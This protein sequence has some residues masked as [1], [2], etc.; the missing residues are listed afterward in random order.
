MEVSNRVLGVLAG[1]IACLALWS[2]LG[3]TPAVQWFRTL[4]REERAAQAAL[5]DSAQRLGR[6]VG[7]AA[8]RSRVDSALGRYPI[9][10]APAVVKLGVM[11]GADRVAESLFT[12][13]PRRA[14]ARVPTRLALVAWSARDSLPRWTPTSFALL[15]DTTRGGNCT[16]FHLAFPGDTVLDEYD[17]SAWRSAPWDGAVGACWYLAEFGEPGPEVRAWLDSRYWD[18]AR[19]VPPLKGPLISGE[20]ASEPSGLLNRVFGDLGGMFYGESVALEGCAGRRPEFCEA[21]FLQS[22]YPPNLLPEGVVGAGHLVYST[23]AVSGAWILEMP[24]YV[25]AS[26]LAL[27]VEDLGPARF[28]EFWTSTAPVAEAFQSVAGMSLGEWY[29][30]QLL[31][32]RRDAGYPEPRRAPVWPSAIGVLALALGGTMRLAR[33]RQV[34]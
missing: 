9:G 13:I 28:T 7:I 30:L 12:S 19:S 29:R 2:L 24:N 18:V 5:R 8:L 16:T 11:G 10:G 32:Q 34:R 33:R 14:D 21:A 31:E 26:L 27:M 23:A 25:S 4:P 17:I 1:A 22:P 20:V 6:Q 15:P 3:R